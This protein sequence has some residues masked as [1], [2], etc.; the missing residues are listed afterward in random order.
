MAWRR[1]DGDG[2]QQ[3]EYCSQERETLQPRRLENKFDRAVLP[4]VGDG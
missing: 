4:A 3:Q 2:R 1:L